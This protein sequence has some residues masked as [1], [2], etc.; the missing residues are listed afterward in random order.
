[1]PSEFMFSHRPP[2]SC[3]AVRGQSEEAKEWPQELVVARPGER[4]TDSK[5]KVELSLVNSPVS[6]DRS[7]SR[8]RRLT[9]GSIR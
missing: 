4:V 2:I 8:S 6:K 1:M 3:L 7:R 5:K 9:T